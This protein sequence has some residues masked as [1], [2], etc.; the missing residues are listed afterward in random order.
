MKIIYNLCGFTILYGLSIFQLTIGIIYFKYNLSGIYM[1]LKPITNLGSSYLYMEYIINN[2]ISINP[3]INRKK[4]NIRTNSLLSIY[5]FLDIFCIYI[6]SNFN[7]TLSHFFWFLF[8]FDTI[9]SILSLIGII[10]YYF[11][12]LLLYYNRNL[13]L[14]NMLIN[15]D[16]L[17]TRSYDDSNDHVDFYRY[18]N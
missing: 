12:K 2:I 7:K 17:Q 11:N 1:L 8:M 16:Y 9:C 13:D 6:F 3:I 18:D 14:N 15:N 5:S 10:I 4:I